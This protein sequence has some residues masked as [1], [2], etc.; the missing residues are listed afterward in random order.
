MRGMSAL[1]PPSFYT[2][3]AI[4]FSVALAAT[5]A[6]GAPATSLAQQDNGHATPAD[7]Q[8]FPG[9]AVSQGSVVIDGETIEYTARAGT[10]PLTD[11][12]GTTLAN[13][14]YISYT[15]N[16]PTDVSERPLLFS[17]NGGPGSASMWMHIGLVGPRRVKLGSGGGVN[18]DHSPA[19]LVPPAAMI[20][21]E[22]S[23]LDVADLVFIDPVSTGY[24]R[25]LP[26]VDASQFHGFAEDIAAVGEFIRLYVS[27]NDRWD[28]PK[29]IIGE[30][31]GTR[32][33]AGLSATLQGRMGMDLNGLI[34][35]SA[36]S[37][38]EQFG[39][40][41]ILQY[42]LNIP[43]AAAT[44]WYHRKLPAELQSRSL[45]DFLDEVEAFALD[46]FA[47]ALLRGNKLTK[48]ERADMVAKLARYT[49]LTE[50]YV[51]AIHMRIDMNRFRKELLRDQGLTVGRLD[52]RFTGNDYDSGGEGYEY[53]AA[54][55]AI[56]GP[57]TQTFNT[58]VR[59]ELGY[60]S[61]L[62][63]AVSGNVRPWNDPP[64]GMNLL[65]TLRS[66]MAQNPH[67]HVMIADGYYDKLYF[68]PEFTFSQFDFSGLRDRVTIE[69]YESGHMMYIDEPSLAKMK[70][71]MAA[72]VARALAR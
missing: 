51:D 68:W 54:M 57:F 15:K 46:E 56:R 47:V 43:H 20:D 4:A 24:S 71:D 37:M 7:V 23:M 12:D 31:Y 69:T 6:L 22:Y 59:D 41:G 36:G 50:A 64:A 67:L 16:G 65:E 21:N 10:L 8:H 18:R 14:F 38:G 33:A 42:A 17:F 28:S 61:D 39:N 27:R 66:S 72:F 35:V 40:F 62:E 70:G 19:R 45:R 53:D 63:Y 32:R 48:Q 2:A 34:L 26:G 60:R 13:V 25:A 1:P 58:F 11:S 5:F 9:D 44:A 49:G 3:P 30:S 52:S 29:F 55:A